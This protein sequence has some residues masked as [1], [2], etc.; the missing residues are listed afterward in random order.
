LSATHAP[1]SVLSSVALVLFLFARHRPDFGLRTTTHPPHGPF[2]DLLGLPVLS[3]LRSL[4]V[5][6]RTLPRRARRSSTS[7]SMLLALRPRTPGSRNSSSEW[8]MWGGPWPASS[9]WAKRLRGQAGGQTGQAVTTHIPYPFHR[10]CVAFELARCTRGVFGGDCVVCVY[11]RLLLVIRVCAAPHHLQSSS[12]SRARTHGPARRW[13]AHSD[14]SK[15]FNPRT[16]AL[17]RRV[18]VHRYLGQLSLARAKFNFP[19]GEKWNGVDELPL[20]LSFSWTDVFKVPS[21]FLY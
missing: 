15:R 8:S 17:T 7:A 16:H 3:L 9:L 19:I 20:K 14:T 13:R 11:V 21:C 1:S 5:I 4:A 2:L 10:L 12:S 18:R 6:P